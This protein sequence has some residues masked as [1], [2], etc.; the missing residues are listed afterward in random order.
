M[1]SMCP[2]LLDDVTNLPVWRIDSFFRHWKSSCRDILRTTESLFVRERAAS[3]CSPRRQIP[4][5]FFA[6]GFK[7]KH[8]FCDFSVARDPT[9]SRGNAGKIHVIKSRKCHHHYLTNN[10]SLSQLSKSLVSQKRE[11]EA[12]G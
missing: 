4:F 1:S 11:G 8:S 5:F 6:L 10:L 3:V 7:D 12:A 2:E 9:G